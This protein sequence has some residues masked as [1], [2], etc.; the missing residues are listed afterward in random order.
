MG[1]AIRDDAFSESVIWYPDRERMRNY[2]VISVLD[3]LRKTLPEV[4]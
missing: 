1:V 2:A 4:A 3:F